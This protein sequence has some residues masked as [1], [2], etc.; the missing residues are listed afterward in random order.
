MYRTATVTIF[1]VMDQVHVTATIRSYGDPSAARHLH[2]D[3]QVS[4][5]LESTGESND[6][7]WLLNAII[8]LA[9][10]L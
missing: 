10:R 2:E 6:E 4:V 1:D 5:D 7:R 3:T 9:E 8:A